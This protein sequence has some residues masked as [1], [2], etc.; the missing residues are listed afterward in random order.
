MHWEVWG[1]G[2]DVHLG[3]SRSSKVPHLLILLLSANIPAAARDKFESRNGSY[4]VTQM[5]RAF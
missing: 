4:Q 2:R 5:H 1:W 3:C